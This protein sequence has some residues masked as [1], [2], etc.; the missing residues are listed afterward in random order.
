MAHEAKGGLLNVVAVQ[1]KLCDEAYPFAMFS[2]MANVEGEVHQSVKDGSVAINF[3]PKRHMWAMPHNR[4][5]TGVDGGVGDFSLVGEDIRSRT[6]MMGGHCEIRVFH[7]GGNLCGVIGQIVGVG[8]GDD[9]RCHAGPVGRQFIHARS[10]GGV[11]LQDRDAGAR[12]CR[13][14]VFWPVNGG[15][16]QHAVAAPLAF[17]N[18]GLA[19]GVD[20]RAGTGVGHAQLVQLRQRSHDGVLAIGHIVGAPHG[21]MIG[22]GTDSAGGRVKSFALARVVICAIIKTAFQITE[23]DICGAQRV[24]DLSEGDVGVCNPLKIHVPS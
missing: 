12:Y 6:P 2:M 3:D 4:A 16:L 23:H 11:R 15:A 5:S 21:V 20:V 19:C 13:F 18:G 9:F 14:L 1:D 7:Q 22:E 10:I 17:D 24:C 8:P